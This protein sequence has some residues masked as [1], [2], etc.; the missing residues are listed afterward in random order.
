MSLILAYHQ[1]DSISSSGVADI[2]NY[3]F[4]WSVQETLHGRVLE[5]TGLKTWL[6]IKLS[7]NIINLYCSYLVSWWW[8]L[9]V[10]LVTMIK[11]TLSK[12]SVLL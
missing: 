1:R 10:L 7:I 3:T 5:F 11:L 9:N 2:Q 12:Y 4:F 8:W 6:T